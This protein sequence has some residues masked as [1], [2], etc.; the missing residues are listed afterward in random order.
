MA[1]NGNVVNEEQ[2]ASM[3]AEALKNLDN[4]S[5]TEIDALNTVYKVFKKS[6]PFSKRKYITAMFVKQSHGVRRSF[7]R[8]R[9]G[10]KDRSERGERYNS[11]DRNERPERNKAENRANREGFEHEERQRAPRVTIDASVAKSIFISIGRNRRVFPRDLLGLLVAVAGIERER[12]GEI[13]VLTSYSFVQLYAEDCEKTIAALNGY[14]Y[15]G[16]KLSVGYSRKA[17]DE[18]KEKSVADGAEEKSAA[19]MG[20]NN[21][22]I[23]ENVTNTAHADEMSTSESAKIAA[24]Q[25]EFAARQSSVSSGTARDENIQ[26]FF[27]TTDDG[28]VKS[29][30]NNQQ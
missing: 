2:I 20:I 15:R 30:F 24:E 12:I 9:F 11:R 7:D 26:S 3:L 23:P 25:S 8:D 1:Y 10:S 14:D 16:R 22:P 4:A 6:V 28:Q 13:K 29:R 5:D 21:D 18:D 19:D 17:D 27:E